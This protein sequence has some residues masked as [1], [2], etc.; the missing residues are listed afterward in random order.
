MLRGVNRQA[1]TRAFANVAA[2]RANHLQLGRQPS[3]FSRE[4][5]RKADQ[6]RYRALEANARVYQYARRPKP[7]WS[8]SNSGLPRMWR[9]CVS[10]SSPNRSPDDSRSFTPMIRSLG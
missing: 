3:T 5:A 8:A 1:I 7:C 6:E 2:L 9:S 4:G 10:T